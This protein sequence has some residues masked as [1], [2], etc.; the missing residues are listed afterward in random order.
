MFDKFD[1]VDYWLELCDDDLKAAKNLYASK[2]YLWMSFICHLIVE[3]T[4]KAMIAF[5]T[6]EVPPKIHDLAKLAD[7]AEMREDLSE[8]QLDF[9]EELTPFNIE[10]R[11]P[12]YKEKMAAKLSQAYCKNLLARTEEFLCWTK[13]QLEK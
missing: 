6:E 11:Y 3:K 4:I 2:D 8:E 12:M 5:K 13:Q 9:L 1:K 7:K 10:A